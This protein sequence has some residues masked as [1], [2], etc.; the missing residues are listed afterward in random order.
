[1]K[2]A[3]KYTCKATG[4]DNQFTKQRIGQA[5]CSVSCG[6]AKHRQDKLKDSDRAYRRRREAIRPLSWHLAQ[7]QTQFN[8]FIRLRDAGKPCVSCGRTDLKKI[9]AGHYRPRGMNSSLRYNELNCFLQCEPCN[10]N[11]SGN[12]IPY[13]VELI[14]RIGLKLVEWLEA[15]NA[16]TKW[17][18]LEAKHIR[19]HYRLQC[20]AMS[21]N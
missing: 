18:I 8:K 17:T 13:R 10:S 19:E 7:A 5:V 20:K 11:L 1:M 21:E 2:P 16:P 14:N 3:R 9:N 12:L 15:Q 6:I 4:C